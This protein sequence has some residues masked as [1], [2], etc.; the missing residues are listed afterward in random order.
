[1][2]PSPPKFKSHLLLSSNYYALLDFFSFR[3]CTMEVDWVVGRNECYLPHLS[4]NLTCFFVVLI[5][6]VY[7][8]TQTH[9]KK[10]HEVSL[11][12]FFINFYLLFFIF[13]FLWQSSFFFS[14]FFTS[15]LFFSFDFLFFFYKTINLGTP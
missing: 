15:F 3:F 13:L 10:P 8:Q 1:M 14:L 12:S 7:I 2:L 4:S 5:M 11:L 6:H 9:F